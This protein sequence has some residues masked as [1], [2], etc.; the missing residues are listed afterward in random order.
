[1]LDLPVYPA[2]TQGSLVE[3]REWIKDQVIN[4]NGAKCPCCLQLAK[5]YRRKLNSGMAFALVKMYTEHGTNWQ[6]KTVTL[7]GVASAARD[8]SLLRHWGLLEEASKTRE[9]GG[10]A[11]WWRVTEAGQM[12]AQGRSMVHSHVL[13]YDNRFRGLVGEQVTI[14]DCLG[15]SFDLAE[16]LAS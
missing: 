14:Q 10:H 9:D 5:Q 2:G 7:R 1:M 16:L 4:G 6:D 11:G 8:E 13:L 12:F 15:K 3:A